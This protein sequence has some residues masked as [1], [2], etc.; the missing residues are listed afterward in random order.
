MAMVDFNVSLE[1]GKVLLC[2]LPLFHVNGVMVTGL[3]PWSHGATVVLV[4]PLGDPNDAERSS[5][6]ALMRF[7]ARGFAAALAPAER[8]ES[9]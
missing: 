3:W 2:G 6:E 5:Y 4:D 8:G 9:K 7:N 1:P